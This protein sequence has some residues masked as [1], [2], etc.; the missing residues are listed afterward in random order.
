MTVCD[1]CGGDCRQAAGEPPRAS[2]GEYDNVLSGHFLHAGA[3]GSVRYDLALMSAEL[4]ETCVEAVRDFINAGPGRGV[5]V[6]ADTMEEQYVFSRE[7][8]LLDEAGAMPLLT[9][10]RAVEYRRW[11]ETRHGITLPA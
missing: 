2:F 9:G 3:Y 4:C 11:L 8:G 10:E 1:R 5:T 6:I 7:Q